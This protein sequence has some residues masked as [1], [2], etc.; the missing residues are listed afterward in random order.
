MLSVGID[1]LIVCLFLESN[2]GKQMQN[3]KEL[4]CHSCNKL[5]A[6]IATKGTV[7]VCARCKL[8]NEVKL[9]EKKI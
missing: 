1:N 8:R 9:N 2:Q 7:I 6:E 5:L 3:E 4:R